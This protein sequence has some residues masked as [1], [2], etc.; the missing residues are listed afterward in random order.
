MVVKIQW[1][2]RG[3]GSFW[4]SSVLSWGLSFTTGIFSLLYVISHVNEIRTLTISQTRMLVNAQATLT[5]LLYDHALRIRMKAETSSDSSG[6]RT[7]TAA[8]TPD[9]ASIAEPEQEEATNGNS[10]STSTTAVGTDSGGKGKQKAQAAGDAKKPAEDLKDSQGKNLIGKI[11]NLVTSDL[12]NITSGRDFMIPRECSV[13]LT[14][15]RCSIFDWI[16]I[17]I[18]CELAFGVIFLFA[19]LGWR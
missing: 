16:V 3:C 11:N 10:D 18:P 15:H 6:S 1:S 12:N 19:I 2:S 9:S 13:G 5:Q 8:P 4:C 14:T 7:S 17:V